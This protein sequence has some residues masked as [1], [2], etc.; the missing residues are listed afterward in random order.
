MTV[1]QKIKLDGV[2]I[3]KRMMWPAVILLIVVVLIV[4]STLVP[5]TRQTQI[6]ELLK[7]VTWPA[8]VVFV[9]LIFRPAIKEL[10]GQAEILTLETPGSPKVTITVRRAEV[11]LDAMLEEVD[12]LLDDLKPEADRAFIEMDKVRIQVPPEFKRD[13][14]YHH[15]ILRV[16]RY[17]HLIRPSEGGHWN[18]GKHIEVTPFGH[19][20]LQVRLEK[21]K[22]RALQAKAEPS[23]TAQWTP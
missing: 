14:F 12:T 15:D 21:I 23:M 19:L 11:I 9:V 20:V 17:R 8:V 6:T 18:V 16:L 2:A 22:E 1:K 13:S 3:L 7:V 4:F 10:I 5:I